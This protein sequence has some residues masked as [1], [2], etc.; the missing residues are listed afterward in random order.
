MTSLQAVLQPHITGA[1]PA[2]SHYPSTLLQ[3]TLV[4]AWPL[5]ARRIHIP[6]SGHLWL[7]AQL[8]GYAAQIVMHRCGASPVWRE[9][10]AMAVR[11]NSFGFGAGHTVAKLWLDQT[12]PVAGPFA[13]ARHALLML[14]SSG[15]VTQLLLQAEVMR[16]R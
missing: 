3:A 11:L 10:C 4:F 5:F 8:I 1:L 12:P 16:F 13:L 9:R 7:G 14:F 2:S 15:A 6:A